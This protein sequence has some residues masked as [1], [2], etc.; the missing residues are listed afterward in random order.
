MTA[1]ISQQI[2]KATRR[3]EAHKVKV[4]KA[5]DL[6]HEEENKLQAILDKLGVPTVKAALEQER[7]RLMAEVA[8]VEE[9]S[10]G[11]DG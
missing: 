1:R 10:A 5:V 2:I 6:V 8:K 4:E 7:E 9:T 3:I 11:I